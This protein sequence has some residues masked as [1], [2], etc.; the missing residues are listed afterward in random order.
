[1]IHPAVPEHDALLLEQAPLHAVRLRAGR[2]ADAALRVQHAMP[3]QLERCG[4]DLERVADEAR[5]PRGARAPRDAA[6]ARDFPAGNLRDRL[7]D[8]LQQ[9]AVRHSHDRRF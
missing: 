4:R 2:Q 9:L 1:M 3:G 5:A 6:V 7:P 8:A